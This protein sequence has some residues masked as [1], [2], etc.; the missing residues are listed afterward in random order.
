MATTSPDNLFSPDASSAYNL[1]TD[2]AASMT[3]VQAALNLRANSYVGTSAQRIAFTSA[4]EGVQWRDTDG[5]KKLYVRQGGLWVDAFP[6]PAGTYNGGAWVHL[7]AE[8]GWSRNT[9]NGAPRAKAYGGVG[10][11]QGGLYGGPANS[12]ATKLPATFP[13][14]SRDTIAIVRS[15]ADTW[16]VATIT[17]TGYIKLSTGT[18]VGASMSWPI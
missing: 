14:V 12:N 10:Y 18:S 13:A 16:A 11:F 3:S 2:L 4:A 1:T 5:D 8:S 15:N 9:G 6:E 7:E 17:T